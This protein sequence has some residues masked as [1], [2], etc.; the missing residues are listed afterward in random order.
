MCAD[1]VCVCVDGASSALCGVQR[2]PLWCTLVPVVKRLA[3][4]GLGTPSGV[5]NGYTDRRP[6]RIHR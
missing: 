3:S 5:T 4:A 6:S 2:T 1:A